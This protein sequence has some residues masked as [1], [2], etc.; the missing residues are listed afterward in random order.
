MNSQDEARLIELRKELAEVEA[1]IAELTSKPPL[2]M[3][4]IDLKAEVL[5]MSDSKEWKEFIIKQDVIYNITNI[6]D[7]CYDAYKD[8]MREDFPNLKPKDLIGKLGSDKWLN[9]QLKTIKK[10]LDPPNMNEDFQDTAG[11]C[12]EVAWD[13]GLEVIQ[14]LAA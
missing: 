4:T 9:F 12:D 3:P 11:G 1:K 6:L 5:A 7:E 10:L 2:N 8:C 13:A 14:E